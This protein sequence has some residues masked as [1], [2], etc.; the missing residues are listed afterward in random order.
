MPTPR[1]P[2]TGSRRNEEARAA[3]LSAATE[4]L[5]EHGATGVTIDRLA[6]HAGV[7]RQTIYR[8]WSSKDAVLLDALIHSAEHAV[9]VP[10]TGALRSDLEQFLRATFEAAAL[11]RNRRAL[12]TAAVAAQDDPNLAEALDA[13]LAQ[14]RTALTALIE[15]AHARG[16]IPATAPIP[17]AVDQAFGVLWYQILFR[18]NALHTTATDLAA[19]L[20]TQ[21]RAAP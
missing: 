9:A 8:W 12:I 11:E 5:A 19:A 16:E 10:D 1:R 21:L 2:H 6:A 17:L 7:G 18:P 13:F 3:I 4:L 14:R 15:R 20:T